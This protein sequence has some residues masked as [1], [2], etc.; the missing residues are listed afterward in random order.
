MPSSDYTQMTQK[1]FEFW[2]EQMT[3]S[4]NDKDFIRLLM[5]W[6]Q[7]AAIPATGAHAYGQ[8]TEKTS[9]RA[10]VSPDASSLGVDELARRVAECERRIALLEAALIATASAR[11]PGAGLKSLVKNAGRSKPRKRPKK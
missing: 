3:S 1:F 11:T 6:M 9:G 4:V 10:A 5:E 2:Q 8:T 7:N